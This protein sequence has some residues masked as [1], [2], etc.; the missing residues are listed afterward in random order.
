MLE[1]L[2]IVYLEEWELQTQINCLEMGMG[3]FSF[4]HPTPT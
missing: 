4:P 3:D 1:Y 2:A